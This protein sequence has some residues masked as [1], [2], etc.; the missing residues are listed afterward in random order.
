MK[1]GTN[2][3]RNILFAALVSFFLTPLLYGISFNDLNLS[4]DDRLLF[5]AESEEQM[6]LFISVLSDMSIAQLTA[7]PEKTRL[8]D[9]GKTIFST[10]RFGAAFIPVSGGLPSPVPGLSSIVSRTAAR[11]ED[12]LYLTVSPNGRWILNIERTSPAFGNLVLIDASSGAKRIISDKVEMPSLDFPAKWSPDSRYFVYSK[13]SRLYYFP[14]ISDMSALVDERFRMIGPG[15]VTSVSWNASNHFFY[16]TGNILYRVA[17]PELFTRTVYG[18]FLSIGAVAGSIPVDFDSALDYYWLSPDAKSILI[19]KN[20][21]GFF[22]FPLR[23]DRAGAASAIY[24][25][26]AIPAGAEQ[27]SALWASSG[28]LAII[29]SLKGEIMVQR[30]EITGDTI[31]D[32]TLKNVPSSPAGSLSPDGSKAAFWGKEGLE[33]WDFTNWRLIQI[34]RNEP[35]Y[36]C[37]WI[38]NARLISGSGR[39][40]EEV[41]I[42]NPSLSR[43]ICLSSVDAFGFEPGVREK[44]RIFARTRNE[45]FVTD[46]ESPWEKTGSTQ[47]PQAVLSTERFRVFLEPQRAGYLTNTPMVRSVY[48][49]GTTPLVTSLENNSQAIK[50]RVALCFDLYDDDSGLYQTLAALRARGVKATFFLNGDFI[51]RSPAAAA[52]IT[53]AGHEAASMFY[54]PIDFSDTR[55]RITPEFIAQ[56]LARNEDEFFHVTGKELSPI[57]HPPFFRGSGA[58]NSA[59]AR[60][61]YATVSR[62]IDPGDWL[63]REDAARLNL[64]RISPSQMIERIMEKVTANAVIPVRLGLLTGGNDGYLFQRVDLLLDAL[65]RSGYE[66]VPVSGVIRE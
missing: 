50:A 5:K 8:V 34:L 66:I 23:A 9:N 18:D 6:T 61:G 35:V 49:S 2:M 4:N 10:S 29:F 11:P 58:I 13:D 55:Y 57:W 48:S 32:I 46:G 17:N 7:F 38:D 1:S 54:A 20:G 47:L 43:Q 16:L 39:L 3:F 24:P 51:R 53:E 64:P 52:A 30:F 41:D 28:R 26:A 63:S 33:L 12:S 27:I 60:A 31:R 21:K 15:G 22:I 36:S 40:I 14:I 59:A 19:N 37:E 42:A 44:A 62:T 25:Y 65:I 56:G 45:W